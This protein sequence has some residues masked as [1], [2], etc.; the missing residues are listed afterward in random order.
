MNNTNITIT[1][2]EK[3]YEFG[4]TEIILFSCMVGLLLFLNIY[5]YI[6]KTWFNCG[7]DDLDDETLVL[8]EDYESDDQE[9]E[10]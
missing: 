4:I 9:T 1:E 2:K 3:W 8:I 10:V 7:F 5:V 6:Y